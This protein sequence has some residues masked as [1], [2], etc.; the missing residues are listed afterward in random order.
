MDAI[1]TH[2][3]DVNFTGVSGMDPDEL[4]IG[5]PYGGCAISVKSSMKCKF[6]PISS[7]KQTNACV[8]AAVA[9]IPHVKKREKQVGGIMLNQQVGAQSFGTEYGKKTA[10]RRLGGCTKYARKHVNSA[11]SGQIQ[12]VDGVTEQDDI[13]DLFCEKYKELYNCV[14]YDETKMEDLLHELNIQVSTAVKMESAM[15]IIKYQSIT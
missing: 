8:Q 12:D 10:P 3:G 4:L 1:A 9:T 6:V 5:R 7:K 15:M 13:R 14:A 11:T 2:I